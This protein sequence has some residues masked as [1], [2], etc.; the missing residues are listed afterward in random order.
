MSRPIV[1]NTIAI[2]NGDVEVRARHARQAGHGG[3][4]ASAAARARRAL[5]SGLRPRARHSN[6][7]S[8]HSRQRVTDDRIEALRSLMR[9]L[10]G[11][12]EGQSAE[13]NQR[14]GEVSGGAEPGSAPAGALGP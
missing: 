2:P 11:T 13:P 14:S 4:A 3:T 7:K 9:T 1:K 10:E 6:A 5:A 12:T 8:D